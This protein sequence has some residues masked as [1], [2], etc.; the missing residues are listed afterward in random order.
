M[1]KLRFRCSFNLFINDLFFLVKEAELANLA[2][3]NT[4][5]VG[6]TD[7]TELLEILQKECVTALNWVKTSNVILNPDK[8]QSMIISSK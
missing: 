1:C 7:L 4:T 8:F 5:Y 6:S 2:H 3:D